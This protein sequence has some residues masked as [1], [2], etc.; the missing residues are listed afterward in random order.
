MTSTVRVENK[1][2][3]GTVEAF[4]LR[5]EL[6]ELDLTLKVLVAII[7]AQ[8]EAMGDVGLVMYDLALLPPCLTIRVLSYSSQ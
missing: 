7:G 6:L 3:I 4:S 8:W 5:G 2:D 1:S